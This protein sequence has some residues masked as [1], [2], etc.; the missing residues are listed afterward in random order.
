[1]E[2]SRKTCWVCQIPCKSCS[3]S[4]YQLPSWKTAGSRKTCWVCQ[5]PGYARSLVR[6]AA[7]QCINVSATFMED[8]RKTDWV[9]QIPCKSCSHSMYQL[10]SWKTAGRQAGYARSLVRVAATCTLAKQ[11][12]HLEQDSCSTRRRLRPSQPDG[13]PGNKGESPLQ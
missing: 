13:L 7:T 3:H 5:I 8:S 4:M 9:C 6:V 2:D 10:P 1:M 11:G 12:E